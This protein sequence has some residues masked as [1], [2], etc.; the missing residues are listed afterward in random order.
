MKKY[1][2]III[3]FLTFSGFAQQLPPMEPNLAVEGQ[4]EGKWTDWFTENFDLTFNEKEAVYY[5]ISYFKKGVANGKVNYYRNNGILLC[6]GEFTNGSQSGKWIWY[7]E[8]SKITKIER[9]T[10]TPDEQYF[11]NKILAMDKALDE[12]NFDDFLR[13]AFEAV[14]FAKDKF[15]EENKDYLAMA[16]GLQANACLFKND[17]ECAESSAIRSIELHT[18]LYGDFSFST[19]EQKI[20][21][22]NIYRESGRSVEAIPV[23]ENSIEIL[24]AEYEENTLILRYSL[25]NL[26]LAY[27]EIGNYQKAVENAEKTVVLS[28]KYSGQNSEEYGTFLYNLA[29][30]N[31]ILENYSIAESQY[32]TVLEISESFHG[33]NSLDYAKSINNFGAYLIDKG[34]YNRAKET[35][36][37]AAQIL[38]SLNLSRSEAYNAVLTNQSNLYRFLGDYERAINFSQQAINLN[39][40]LFEEGNYTYSVDLNNLAEIYRETGQYDKALPLYKESIRITK[41]TLG[42]NH[43]EYA[44]RLNNL[45][46]LYANIGLFEQ[47][48]PLH[49]EEIKITESVFGKNSIHYGHSLNNLAA[50]YLQTD[51]YDLALT[52]LLE[53][54]DIF[55]KNSTADHITYIRTLQN[56][57]QVYQSLSQNKKAIEY[58]DRSLEKTRKSLGENHPE[59]AEILT[60][61]ALSEIQLFQFDR[62]FQHLNQAGEIL[63]KFTTK[64]LPEYGRIS[65]S[66]GMLY[67]YFGKPVEAETYL[68]ESLE[69]SK[70]IFDSHHPDYLRTVN[71]LTLAY[72]YQKEYFKALETIQEVINYTDTENSDYSEQADF[73]FNNLATIYWYMKEDEK[74]MTYFEKAFESW[75]LKVNTFFALM[76]EKDKGQFLQ[77][78]EYYFKLYQNFLTYVEKTNPVAG[79][80]AYNLELV[81][82]GLILNSSLDLNQRI[83]LLRDEDLKNWLTDYKTLKKT[84][85]QEYSKTENQRRK[86]LKE[87]ETQVENLEFKINRKTNLLSESKSA[88]QITWRD[89]QKNLNKNEVAIEFSA[90]PTF[91]DHKFTDTVQY[92]AVVLRKNDKRPKLIPLFTQDELDLTIKVPG[93]DLNRIDNLYLHRGSKSRSTQRDFKKLYDLIWAPL[94]E[95]IK[96]GQTIYFAPSG[97]LHQ[98]AFSTIRT[99]EGDYLS[100]K[101]NL[102]Q[103]S[104]TAKILNKK[105][106]YRLQ[107]IALFGG[108]DYDA[109][110]KILAKK[111][112]TTTKDLYASRSLTEDLEREDENWEYLS[113]TLAEVKSIRKIALSKNASTQYFT[114]NNALEENFKLLNGEQS[115]AILHIST[116]GFFFP[117]P[118]E[119]KEELERLGLINEEQNIFKLSDDPLNRAGLLFAGANRTWNGEKTIENL[120]DGILTAYEVSQIYLPNTKLVVLSACETG[121][122]E[123]K[124][125]EGVFGL[126]RAFKSAGVE[127]LLMSLW[128]VPDK[129]TAEFMEE[130][131]KD[132]FKANDIENSYLKAQNYMKGK[133]RDTP[134]KWAAFVLMK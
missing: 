2:Y 46:L 83:N 72:F 40:E 77:N 88:G 78:Q 10:L 101:Y 106:K 7:D 6:S 21:L 119:K 12:D 82:K 120:E 128:Q 51:Q 110:E 17:K 76:T 66:L 62:A 84:L 80:F 64:N 123:I 125:S 47:A 109:D 117:D 61:L 79:E 131:Y 127:Y 45:A 92:T 126:Q 67:L 37:E 74:A 16:Y 86:D 3:L 30:Y 124:G 18:D 49:L 133:Y 107:S 20:T 26:G 15:E 71:N 1:F 122:G 28:E 113:G 118:Q 68:K 97:T 112:N 56:I 55:D 108:I 91:S 24:E 102:K 96:E 34:D 38:K 69:I 104:T 58:F 19:L 9:Y 94:E 13:L 14:E 132:L 32:I 103:V 60:G 98:I 105:E 39:K 11:E 42:E 129:E 75:Q 48:L 25:N 35:L 81:T 99:Q 53:A 116:H 130:F 33:K 95:Y 85:T 22:A 111:L 87:V 52:S 54:L 63:E 100:D 121:L 4:R 115:P 23:Y 8:N 50:L 73:L 59:Y 134:N 31:K 36:D 5:S 70:E 89:I 114:G 93:K 44:K 90:Y 57:A 27:S 65:N 43:P 41:N 29:G